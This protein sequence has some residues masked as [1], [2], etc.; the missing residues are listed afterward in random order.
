MRTLPVL[1]QN[2]LDSR[3]TTVCWCWKITRRDGVILGFTNHDRDLTF[4]SVTYEAA[5]GVWGTEIETDLGLSVDNL[6]VEGALSSGNITESDLVSGRYD[7][8]QIDIFLVNWT[9]TSQNYLFKRGNLGE[10]TRGKTIF[11]AEVRG[12]A[13]ILQ[14]KKGRLYQYTC[15]AIVGDS[16]CGVNLDTSTFKGTGTVTS[17]DGK[18]SIVA[19][20][21]G[22][23]TNNWF[24]RGKLTFTS[25]NNNGES[26]EVKT[27][28]LVEG[29]VSI[30][31]WEPFPFIINSSDTFTITAGCDKTFRTCKSKFN[32]AI[33]F[34]GFPHIPGP[35]AIVSYANQGDADQDGGGQFFGRD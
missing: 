12:L 13:H 18:S 14:Q 16:R 1:L 10:I 8:A 30:L 31:L 27:H 17:T 5:T 32:N 3:S 33:N 22:I 11:K 29:T 19:S 2:H 24:N 21:L 28:S 6:N 23:Y 34:R 20:G 25:G 26:K 9:D 15:D 7:N 4:G 35:N